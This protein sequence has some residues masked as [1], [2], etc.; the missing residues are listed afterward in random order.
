MRRLTPFLGMA[1]IVVAAA[2]PVHAQEGPPPFTSVS[3]IEFAPGD[4]DTFAE[5]VRIV[6]EAAEEIGLDARFAWN[7]YRWDNTFWFVS[8]NPTLADL[9]DPNAMAAAFQG[10][11]AE[12]RVMA[13]FEAAGG[14]NALSYDSQVLRI[15][16]ELSYQP[17]TPA[18]GE[19]GPGGVYI[20]EQWVRGGARADWEASTRE[21][22][23][24][25]GAINGGYPVLV[26]E[27]LIGDGG[28][29]FVVI[30]DDPATFYGEG[31]LENALAGTGH[32]EHWA[33]VAERHAGTLARSSSQM[34]M[35]LPDLS[36]QPEGN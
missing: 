34:M 11:A 27:D 31:S 3:E 7:T 5:Q 33:Q 8:S 1:A 15:N 17:E 25:L 26:A 30:F 24:I 35:R 4:A 9:E 18:F 10:T 23:G 21:L 2:M 28:V 19:E 14:L 12:G 16:P 32:E 6:K 13:A 29:S 36:Y 22:M 20:V